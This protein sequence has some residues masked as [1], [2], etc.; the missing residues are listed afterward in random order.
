MNNINSKLKS[1]G[2][3]VYKL[4][5]FILGILFCVFS[6]VLTLCIKDYENVLYILATVMLVFLPPLVGVVF[7]CS[8][9]PAMYTFVMFYAIAPLL[10]SMYNLYYVTSWWDDLLHFAGGVVFAVLGVFMAKFLNRKNNNSLIMTAVFAFCFSLAIAGLWEF[11][12]FGMDTFFGMD[13]QVD[14]II[15][16]INSHLLGTEPGKLGSIENIQSVV[17]NG[18]PMEGYLDI[19]L[20][21]TMQDMMIEGLGATIYCAIFLIDRDRHPIITPIV[22]KEENKKL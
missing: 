16:N 7:K 20:I 19:G 12:E 21:D 15:T 4:C 11:F 13:M 5:I 6:M 8:I 2:L 1:Y 3:S 18:K 22:R 9:N 14:T 17:V 10:G